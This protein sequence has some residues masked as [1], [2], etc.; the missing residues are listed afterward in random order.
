MN[1]IESVGLIEE[2]LRKLESEKMIDGKL[3]F[4]ESLPL[5]GPGTQLDSLGFISF[6]TDLEERISLKT[7][8]ETYIVLNNIE[9]FDINQSKL[10]VLQLA[11][12]IVKL[13]NAS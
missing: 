2:S 4:S 8:E 3:N 10:T 13:T 6:L 1:E 11:H 7:E 5:L 12:H 9:N